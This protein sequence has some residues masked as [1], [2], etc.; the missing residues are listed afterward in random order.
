MEVKTSR[1]Y[2]GRVVDRRLLEMPDGRSAFKL[3][4]VSVVDRWS[5]SPYCWPGLP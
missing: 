1:S 5:R 2:H 4:Y 3:Y